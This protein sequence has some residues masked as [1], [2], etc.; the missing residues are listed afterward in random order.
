MLF[1][2]KCVIQKE[3]FFFCIVRIVMVSPVFFSVFSSEKLHG[4]INFRQ[5]KLLFPQ[6]RLL[7]ISADRKFF[8]KKFLHFSLFPVLLSESVQRLFQRTTLLRAIRLMADCPEEPNI[9]IYRTLIYTVRYQITKLFFTKK[10][11]LL[12]C[13]KR[14]GWFSWGPQFCADYFSCSL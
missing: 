3:V 8:F 10:E 4:K 7:S 6:K 2:K 14:C 5:N 9:A 13:L 11:G 12:T 1:L